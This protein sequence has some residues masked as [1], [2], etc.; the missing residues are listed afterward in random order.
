MDPSL[1]VLLDHLI[2]YAA[3]WT[4]FVSLDLPAIL[5]ND[6]PESNR[7]TL[8]SLAGYLLE[9]PLVYSLSREDG[10]VNEENCLGN[11]DLSLV[12]VTLQKSSTMES[13]VQL[14]PIVRKSLTSCAVVH[15]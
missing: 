7:S 13:S 12:K 8:I 14:T 9:Y 6:A 3:L 2:D 10:T 5:P 11:R 1:R 4:A 15:C